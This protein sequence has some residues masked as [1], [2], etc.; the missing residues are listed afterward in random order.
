M[1]EQ[2]KAQFAEQQ[3]LAN[4]ALGSGDYEKAT[5]HTKKMSA[6]KSAMDTAVEMGSMVNAVKAITPTRPELSNTT[7]GNPVVQVEAPTAAVKSAEE[8]IKDAAVK[9]VYLSHNSGM[10]A[11][12]DS[13]LK[14]LHGSDYMGKFFGQKG[15]F[16]R[17]L[18]NK[19]KYGDSD[20][21]QNVIFT[22]A[23]VK[24]AIEQGVTDISAYKAA[25]IEASDTSGGYATVPVDLQARVIAKQQGFTVM[26]GRASQVDTSSNTVAFVRITNPA[27]AGT[28]AADQ[29]TSAVRV[30]YVDELPSYTNIAGAG[31]AETTMVYGEV[32][33]PVVTQ[34][35][36][37]PF[38][39]NQL[40]DSALNVEAYFAE[41][42]AE[43]TAIRDDNDFLTGTGLRTP[44]GI[45]PG[46][47]NT[48]SLTEVKTNF[49]TT[50]SWDALIDLVA[51]IPAQY[52]PGA[53]WVM[54]RRTEAA[55]L[56]LVDPA[57]TTHQRLW[58]PF[59]FV[60]G[61][62]YAPKMLLGYPVLL[63]ESM[64][65]VAA[66]AYP[67]IFG[68]LNAYQ[69][70]NRIGMSIGRFEDSVL[71]KKNM[72]EFVMRRRLGGK[73]LENYKIAVQKVTT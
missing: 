26:R 23:A 21:L 15:A 35:A 51:A 63:Q 69:I 53:V 56:K 45:L 65:S 20:L 24:A 27:A 64:P 39:K 3:H 59:Q 12:I 72:V 60:G 46:G 38:S 58:Q 31:P 62:M 18:R 9:A 66:N 37:M 32:E 29:Y 61:T 44:Q 5:E 55:I 14:G 17:F 48:L 50:L 4:A 8:G 28:A 36:S 16:N 42:V 57:D 54:N 71:A 47:K 34:M 10:D 40:E 33:I 41:K 22:P 73:M 13:I 25:V 67:I 52:L 68:N 30:T 49:A 7:S 2:L 19:P 1:F 70:V 43:A 6:I 11:E